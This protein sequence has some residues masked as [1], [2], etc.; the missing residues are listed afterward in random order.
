MKQSK[1]KTRLAVIMLMMLLAVCV[2]SACGAN[3]G[4]SSI[5]GTWKK[6]HGDI[7]FFNEDGTYNRGES[8]VLSSGWVL[9][10]NG[11]WVLT[12]GKTNEIQ[13]KSRDGSVSVMEYS[14]K[15]NTLTLD[16]REYE[17]DNSLKL[18]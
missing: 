13:L 8:V 15:G 18:P 4:E 5:I 11:T 1:H 12:E 16:G 7:I 6:N 2:L 9:T 10:D 14:I 17:R 3:T